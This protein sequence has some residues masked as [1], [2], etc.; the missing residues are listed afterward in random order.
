MNY[1][2]FYKLGHKQSWN[3]PMEPLNYAFDNNK[4]KQGI[5][6]PEEGLKFLYKSKKEPSKFLVCSL[7]FFFHEVILEKFVK[8]GITGWGTYPL[9]IFKKGKSKEK[10][11]G[12]HGLKVSGRCGDRDEDR[13]VVVQQIYPYMFE[14]K[15]KGTY[16]KNDEWDYSDFFMLNGGGYIFV[17]Q[18]VKELLIREKVKEAI[19]LPLTE[20]TFEGR[21][22]KD[23][24][25]E[26]IENGTYKGDYLIYGSV[27]RLYYGKGNVP[28][29]VDGMKD[30]EFK[31]LWDI[32]NT[33]E[34]YLNNDLIEK[35]LRRYPD[36]KPITEMYSYFDSKTRTS[37]FDKYRYE[38]RFSNFQN[39]K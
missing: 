15:L 6:L 22:L 25:F 13:S 21:T 18:R 12:Y 9:E 3:P 10:I 26:E 34:N 2:E 7:L 27:A 14:N 33:K 8:E 16:F 32:C 31:K 39:L 1:N 5:E 24:V 35:L 36:E 23:K 20:M 17:T 4:I 11:E 28:D 38:N 19:F 37:K 30:E 29:Y